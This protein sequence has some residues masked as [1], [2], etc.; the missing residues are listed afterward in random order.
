[1]TDEGLGQVFSDGEVII[2]EGSVGEEMYSIQ[3]GSARVMKLTSAGE[4]NLAVLKEGDIFGEMS[5][6]DRGPRSASVVAQGEARILRIDRSK[7]LSTISRDPT[8]VLKILESMSKR[9][10]DLDMG[11]SHLHREEN[12]RLLDHLNVDATCEV[13]LT[14]ALFLLGA[15]CGFITLAE[16]KGAAPKVAASAGKHSSSLE[17]LSNGCDFASGSIEG[18][19]PE[20]IEDARSDR[21][22]SELA[23]EIKSILCVPLV[24][25][26]HHL[27]AIVLAGTSKRFDESDLEVATS[28]GELTSVAVQN[29]ITLERYK[30]TAGKIISDA[31]TS[32]VIRK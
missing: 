16:G 31:T 12:N 25:V 9:I 13:A 26:C 21:R 14:R 28:I 19:K 22:F 20:L 27:G 1:M 4:T 32:F 30:N 23:P 2:A 5:L 3:S 17:K 6:F 24:F 8:I 18:G 15:D 10:R 29:A 7:L 11:L